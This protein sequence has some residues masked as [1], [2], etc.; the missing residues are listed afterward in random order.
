MLTFIPKLSA[1]RLHP[2]AVE[3]ELVRKLGSLDDFGAH[4]IFGGAGSGKTQ[5]VRLWLDRVQSPFAW[6]QLD[7]F[8]NDPLLFLEHL[9]LA[10]EPLLEPG[11]QLPGFFSQGRLALDRHFEFLWDL[12][13]R[14]LAQP[15]ILVLDDAHLIEDWFAHPVLHHLLTQL[16]V[17]LHLVV[18]SRSAVPDSYAREVVNRELRVLGPE[19]LVWG[20]T[21]VEGW[22]RSRWGIRRP[23]K[24]LVG[25]LIEISQ[26]GA[27]VISLLDVEGLRTSGASLEHAAEQVEL[28]S[29]MES[30]LS[31]K[32][33]S[34]DMEALRWLACLG[35]FPEVWLEKLSFSSE[36]KHCI[37]EWKRHSS[38]LIRLDRDES[39]FRFHPLFAEIIRT[40]EPELHPELAELRGALVD[41]AASEG[42]VFD[43]VELSRESRDWTRYWILIQRAGCDWI[44]HGQVGLLHRAL[45]SVPEERLC[46]WDGPLLSLFRAAS[47]LHVEPPRTYALGLDAAQ[48]AGRQD[49]RIWAM[50]LALAASSVVGGGQSLSLLGKVAEELNH[51]IGSEWFVSLPS[52][53]RLH[54][55]KAGLI[56]SM[57]ATDE[58]PLNVLFEQINLA[59][60]CSEDVDLQA[61]V[62]SSMMRIV[63]LHGLAEF[64]EAT[65]LH[66]ARLESVAKTPTAKTAIYNA[67][68]S[69]FLALGRK[70]DCVQA[71]N[72]T[73]AGYSEQSPSIWKIEVLC[74]GAYCCLS[75]QDLKQG[76]RLC[77]ELERLA[78]KVQFQSAALH[79]HLHA[80][81]ISA[82]QHDLE[83]SLYHYKQA[84]MCSDNYGYPFM[85]ITSRAGL[86]VIALE[87]GQVALGERLLLEGDE[88]LGRC[89]MPFAERI[90]A[91]TR[92]YVAMC[93]QPVEMARASF[94]ALFR[95]MRESNSYALA[96]DL[97]PQYPNFLKFALEHEI[98]IDLVRDIIARAPLFPKH[99]PHRAW[100]SLYEVKVLGGFNLI[101]NG[102]SQRDRFATSGRRFELLTFLLWK[103][104]RGVSHDFCYR[105]IWPYIEGPKR[106]K[107]VMRAAL[108]RLREDLGREDAILDIDGVISL[109]PELWSYDAWE[110]EAQLEQEEEHVR[111]QKLLLLRRGFVGPTPFPPGLRSLIPGNGGIDYGPEPLLK[112]LGF[113]PQKVLAFPSVEGQA[114]PDS[115]S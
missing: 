21:Q 100:P 78:D 76:T 110:M 47:L 114:P 85:Q 113:V 64:Y 57:L 41:C 36:V 7:S 61:E 10:I 83:K 82:H 95:L 72:A 90:H 49:G 30:S 67:K 91:G 96:L 69:Q 101:V 98:Q 86:I 15:S 9:C 4:W 65:A 55:L 77:G 39:E 103:G 2:H 12:T 53:L 102:E 66:L 26:G 79:W 3:T 93:T 108:S 97:L 99:R 63:A 29:L 73:L 38:V 17:K 22:L 68:T 28:S 35:S 62:V 43:A 75:E 1:P 74:I 19:Y 88:I 87:L 56:A 115:W 5:G 106:L 94:E 25:T 71:A 42:R 18:I 23:S 11:A 45:A 50:G 24:R 40:G 112:W 46:T 33:A 48:R 34:T 51:H 54:A 89:N 37:S 52:S 81:A 31:D 6:I 13:L 109:N 59:L 8:D 92:A 20:A 105:Y 111:M 14:S 80:A 84:V 16:H 60:D 107:R 44:Q 32:L 58:V 70:S 104:G 27:G